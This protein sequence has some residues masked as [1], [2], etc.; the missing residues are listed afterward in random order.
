MAMTVVALFK[1]PAVVED[2][3]KEIEKL[4]VPKREIETVKEP[5]SF[6]VN[7]VMGFSRLDYE[8]ELRYALGEIGAKE[9]EQ[10]AYVQ[11]L[12]DGGALV[13]ASGTDAV[14]DAAAEIMNRR[15]AVDV[16]KN[17]TPEAELPQPEF[18][19][20][21]PLRDLPVQA[22]RIRESSS[23]ARLFVW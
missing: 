1:N 16:E 19:N 5:V 6:P 13:V 20:A 14:V 3:V 17:R 11:G 4:G 15:G 2:V 23:G 10:V 22:G 12:R 9:P 8:V 7:G 18:S 21:L